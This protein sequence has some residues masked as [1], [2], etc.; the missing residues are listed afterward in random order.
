MNFL[1]EKK[2]KIVNLYNRVTHPITFTNSLRCGDLWLSPYP[3]VDLERV[4]QERTEVIS[5][6][7]LGLGFRSR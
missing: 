6:A 4:L 2:L 5:N 3:V 1:N 7:V